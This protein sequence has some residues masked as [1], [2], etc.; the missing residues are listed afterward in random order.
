MEAD[1]QA[2]VSETKYAPLPGYGVVACDMKMS[3]DI[4]KFSRQLPA[5][6]AAQGYYSSAA[7][8]LVLWALCSVATWFYSRRAVL[9]IGL[10]PIPITA[11]W[12]REKSHQLCLAVLRGETICNHGAHNLC[13]RSCEN[14]PIDVLRGA[15]LTHVQNLASIWNHIITLTPE[16]M[17]SEQF[18]SITACSHFPAFGYSQ[19]LAVALFKASGHDIVSMIPNIGRLPFRSGTISGLSKVS[20]TSAAL[21]SRRPLYAMHLLRHFALYLL[22]VHKIELSTW[23]LIVQLCQWKRNSFKTTICHPSIIALACSD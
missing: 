22:R 5:V 16:Q 21:L 11:S 3:E 20:G 9:I 8:I 12:I 14:L 19:A 1:A 15:M 10:P 17:H 7:P 23:T 6:E 18:F 13:R 4:V 2:N